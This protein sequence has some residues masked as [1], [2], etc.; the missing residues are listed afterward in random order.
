MN[1]ICWNFFPSSLSKSILCGGAGRRAGD[2][3]NLY[4]S[5]G[6]CQNGVADDPNWLTY[7]L[8]SN[9]CKSQTSQDSTSGQKKCDAFSLHQWEFHD[10]KPKRPSLRIDHA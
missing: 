6:T 5:C 2:I 4:F 7:G 1:N 8:F 10:S 3:A 9:E